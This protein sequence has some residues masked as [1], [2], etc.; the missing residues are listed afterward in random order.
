MVRD[1]DVNYLMRKVEGWFP[2]STGNERLS[3]L[4]VFVPALRDAKGYGSQCVLLVRLSS[5]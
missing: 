3:S 2:P 1:V 5:G 4:V